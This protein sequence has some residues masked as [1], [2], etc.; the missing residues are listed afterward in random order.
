[1]YQALYFLPIRRGIVFTNKHDIHV[2]ELKVL[3]INLEESISALSIKK[4]FKSINFLSE[5]Q[6]LVI[7]YKAR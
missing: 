5:T 6:D 4:V 7:E 2:E 3:L 1:M